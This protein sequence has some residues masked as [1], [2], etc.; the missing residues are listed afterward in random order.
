MKINMDEVTLH[1]RDEGDGV[2]VLLMH[3]WPDTG[4][5]W[6]HQT[7]A[8]CAAGYRMVA[9]DLRGF[10]ASS[11]PAE[12]EAYQAE[13]MV[14]DVVGLLDQLGLDRVHV[15][16]HDWGAALGWMTAALLPDRVASL[17]AI[18]VGHPASFRTAGLAQ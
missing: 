3:G 10:G 11:K 9:P 12:V 4:E 7:Q 14:G 6:R 8:L 17:T 13:R 16:G 18:S 1:V 2:P 5:L 15:I